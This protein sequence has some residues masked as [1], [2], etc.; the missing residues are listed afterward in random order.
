MII[1]QAI[2]SDAALIAEVWNLEIRDG[3]STFNSIE[4]TLAE[5]EALIQE[6]GAATQVAFE[7]DVFLGFVTYG[8]FR[9]GIGY[10]HSVEHTIYLTPAAKGQGVG[11]ALMARIYDVARQEGLHTMVAGIAGENEAG[12]AFHKAIGFTETGRMPEIAR[13]FD[14]WMTLVL[15]QREL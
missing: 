13:K 11:R 7:G 2:E 14:R 9:G 1:R 10:R 5:I 15:M 8:A 3:V 12:I 4:K 6:R